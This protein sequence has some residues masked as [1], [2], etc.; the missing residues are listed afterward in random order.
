[1]MAD[2]YIESRVR[3][4]CTTKTFGAGAEELSDEG[5]GLEGPPVIVAPCPDEEEDETVTGVA[6]EVIVSAVVR[7]AY[8]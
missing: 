3:A 2:R 4:S 5:T 7:W 1:M 8:L 6:R